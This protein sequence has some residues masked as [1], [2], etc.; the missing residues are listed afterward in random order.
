[1][2]KP[3][4]LI[5][6]AT[7]FVGTALMLRLLESKPV[8]RITVA[9]RSNVN[10]V[11]AGIDQSVVADL[12][13]GT[14]W[15]VA[16]ADVSSVVHCAARVHLLNDDTRNPLSAF[17]AVNVQGTLNLARQ[18]AAA[19]VRRFVFISTIGVNGAETYRQPFTDKTPAQPH[20]NYAISKHEAELG[21]QAL[22]VKTGME[23][24]IIRPPLVYGPNAPGNFGSLIR[25]LKR[26]IP[27]PLGAIHNQ[28]SLVAL[29]N[30]IDLIVT[31]L[32]HP[33]AANQTFLVSDDEDLSTTQLL[34]R[35]GAALGTPARLLPVP[36][37]ALKLGA[38]LLR[39]PEL[40]Q[41]LCGSLQIDMSK[42]QEL[43]GWRPPFS[44]EESLQKTAEGYLRE[45]GV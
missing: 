6:G 28:R 45:T 26:G 18:A 4:V 22:A 41:R 15:R 25:W 35:M 44:V 3:V 32:T 12:T 40:V 37:S 21:L 17:R 38:A 20:S 31:C 8:T 2:S 5:T 7:G 11:P 43:L 19:G 42:T 24:V 36:M 27:L 30:L 1:M 10:A 34:R 13:E 16:L 23:V 14:N 29:D 33:A 9:T 39:R